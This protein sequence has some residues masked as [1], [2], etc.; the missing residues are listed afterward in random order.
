MV[1]NLPLLQRAGNIDRPCVHTVMRDNTYSDTCMI[2]HGDSCF[3]L[4]KSANRYRLHMTVRRT[5]RAYNGTKATKEL[6]IMC[7]S[8]NIIRIKT[9]LF[10]RLMTRIFNFG[11]NRQQTLILWDREPLRCGKERCRIGSTVY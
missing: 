5:T 6:F 8:A 2:I 9:S 3:N 10:C 11:Y 1:K 7:P 4:E